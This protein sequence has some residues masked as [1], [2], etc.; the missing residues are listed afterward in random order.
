MRLAYVLLP[1]T[2]VLLAVTSGCH[3]RHYCCGGCAAP[4]CAPCG[5]CCGYG[6]PAE[7]PMPPLASP[8]P[9]VVVPQMPMVGPR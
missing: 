2:L 5:S 3:H 8:S 4:C 6:P 1:F 9:A 7:G